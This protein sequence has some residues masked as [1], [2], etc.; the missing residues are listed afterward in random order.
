RKKLLN[1]ISRVR[2]TPVPGEPSDDSFHLP[3]EYYVP[4]V[5]EPLSL[6]KEKEY[7][8][9]GRI[10]ILCIGKL[11]LER[12]NH[13][14]LL[15]AIH[16]LRNTYPIR[17]NIVGAL[18][19]EGNPYYGEIKN[20]IHRNTLGDIVTIKPNV[21]YRQCREEY[22]NHDLFILP[23]R[24]E[25]AAVSHLEA[26]SYGL[27]VICSDTNGTKSYMEE[28]R[29]GFIFHTDNLEDLK[30]KIIKIISK[31]DILIR[32]GKESLRIVQQ[33]YS[34]LRYYNDISEIIKLEFN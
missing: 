21:P 1:T 18:R 25:P 2:I 27:P 32:M 29:N 7:F 24:N 30:D 6:P 20:Y 33:K 28:N 23:S 8:L 34:P 13:I 31:K 3:H 17:L 14:L 11:T 9:D 19:D 26:M 15:K 5:V 10:N 4:F 22:L 12:K 16:D